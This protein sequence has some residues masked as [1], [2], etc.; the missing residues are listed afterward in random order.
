M[1]E[2]LVYETPIPEESQN[3]SASRMGSEGTSLV[4]NEDDKTGND[5]A[6]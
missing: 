1:V 6:G 2:T 5:T 3:G 4:P